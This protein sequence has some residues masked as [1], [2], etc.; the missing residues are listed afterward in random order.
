METTSIEIELNANR[1]GARAGRASQAPAPETRDSGVNRPVVLIVDDVASNLLALEGMLR[2]DDI[3]I[4]TA[5]S[6]RAALDILL[7]RDVAVALLD[8]QMPEMDGFELATLMRGVQKTRYVP[9]IF[10]TAGSME[11]ARVFKG[12]ES[13]AVDYLLKPVDERILRSK[14]DVFVT[15][16]AHRQQLQ[17][18]DH[19]REMFIGILGHDLRNPLNGILMGAEVILT[20]TSDEATRDVAR[21]IL[22]SSDR[23]VQLIN[24]L[25]DLSRCRLGGGISLAPR[26][27]DLRELTEQVLGEFEDSGQRFNVEVHGDAMGSWDADRLL[28]VVSN[29]CGNAVQ[30]SPPSSPIHIRIQGRED[31]VALEVHSVG[32]PIPEELRSSLFE[33]FRSSDDGRPSDRLGLGLYI[34]KQ[35]A[36]AHGGTITFESSEESGTSFLVSLPRRTTITQER[37]TDV[38]VPAAV[39][40]VVVDC[41]PTG[42][43]RVLL[44][45]DSTDLRSTF[46][47]VLEHRGHHV[48]EASDGIEGVA[49]IL[50]EKPDVAIVDVG[51]PGINGYEVA[52]RVRAV[53]GATIRLVAMTGY[54]GD[55]DRAEALRAGFDVQLSKPVDTA[56]VEAVL[57][58]VPIN[59][60]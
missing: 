29:L 45:D 49:M 19:M 26:P 6:G 34:T 55:A 18:A 8:V 47:R 56:A 43:R 1:S 39:A 37:A 13:G 12:Y 14:V 20:R 59:P 57:A 15:L 7:E 52:R 53:L 38:P 31:R 28:Q 32:A 54:S 35:I 5:L 27:A 10:V 11:P 21:R 36:L 24:Q 58:T 25:L 9:I 60:R 30:H 23:M 44:V 4:L 22:R 17:Y 16:E 2:R 40:V 41:A 33:P 42:A 3:D 50:T 51:L 48:S 46:R